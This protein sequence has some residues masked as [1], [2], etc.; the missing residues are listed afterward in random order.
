MREE[1]REVEFNAVDPLNIVGRHQ[2]LEL[3]YAHGGIGECRKEPVE[4]AAS[5]A[6]AHGVSCLHLTLYLSS[7]R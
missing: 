3:L 2:M 1:T 4:E 6:V 7:F 5:F